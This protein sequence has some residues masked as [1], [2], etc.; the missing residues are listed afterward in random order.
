MI[1]GI[2]DQKTLKVKERMTR[3]LHS[4][5]KAHIEEW[6]LETIS[7]IKQMIIYAKNNHFPGNNTSCDK[8]SGCSFRD[9]CDAAP[10]AR[11]FKL[12]NLFKKKTH[13]LYAE[14]EVE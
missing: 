3:I 9:V 2:G 8:Y 6:E 1:N 4:Y 14:T 7:W 5:T 12:E 10:V 13:E 11:Q